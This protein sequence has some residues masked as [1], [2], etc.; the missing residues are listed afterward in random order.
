MQ[1]DPP[2]MTLLFDCPTMILSPNSGVVPLTKSNKLTST[3]LLPMFP[4]A[5]EATPV[6]LYFHTCSEYSACP[7][8]S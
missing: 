2:V 1:W 8:Q 6:V 4:L 3:K 5:Q 7:F